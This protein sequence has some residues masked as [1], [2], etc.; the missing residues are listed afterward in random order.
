M[1]AVMEIQEHLD[2]AIKWGIAFVTDTQ[3]WQLVN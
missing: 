2:T 3:K 1:E